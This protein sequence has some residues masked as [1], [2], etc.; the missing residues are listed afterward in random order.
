[1]ALDLSGRTAI[2]TG[3]SKGIG[4]SIAEA[5]ARANANVVVSA[6]KAA[7]V[8]EAARRLES[9][10]SGKVLGIPCDVGKL[11]D[12]KRL[13]S[14]TAET[15]GGIDILV[16]NAGFGIFA[17]IDQI[18]P[19]DW[20]R[21]IATNLSGV[22]YC[23]HQAIPHL[24][25]SDDAWIINI[26]SLAGKNPFAGGSAYNASKFGLVGFSEAMMLDVR[27]Q[28]IRVSYIMPGSV[29]TYFNH[30]QPSDQGAWKIQPEDIGQVV[31]DLLSLPKN[32]LVS[33]IEMRPSRPPKG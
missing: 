32:S 6:R 9:L 17:P 29:E 33:R 4:Y 7:E 12:V 28:G 22:F 27:Q 18:A 8:T 23:C 31:M 1:M 25:K 19:E 11:D 24:R 21:L 3:S 2:V 20:D 13:V 26:A 30:N 10:G 14:Q 16:N 5:L 15:L